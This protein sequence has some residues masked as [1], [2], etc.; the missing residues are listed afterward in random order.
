MTKE[1]RSPNIEKL[2]VSV[3]PFRHW[4]FVI[5]SSFVIRHSDLGVRVRVRKLQPSPR[6][7]L[8]LPPGSWKAARTMVSRLQPAHF[9]VSRRVVTN[10]RLGETMGLLVLFAFV[11]L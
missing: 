6:Q 5:P 9:G 10:A 7:A 2:W 11:S 1:I 8:F 4:D 3:C